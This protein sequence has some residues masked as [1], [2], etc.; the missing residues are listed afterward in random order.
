MI[1]LKTFSAS[2]GGRLGH[3]RPDRQLCGRNGFWHTSNVEIEA[4]E[5]KQ[6]DCDR[7]QDGQAL[8]T[9]N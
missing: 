9:S 6:Y 3:L 1:M 7:N 4:D 2:D 8:R 5:A